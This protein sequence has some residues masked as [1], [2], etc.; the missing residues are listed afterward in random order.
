MFS[1]C[2]TVQYRVILNM[3][4]KFMVYCTVLLVPWN[5]SQPK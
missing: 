5:A 3:S 1:A 4:Q 2:M